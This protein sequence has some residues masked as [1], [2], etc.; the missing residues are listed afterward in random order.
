MGRSNRNR[1]GGGNILLVGELDRIDLVKTLSK[2]GD[3]EPGFQRGAMRI[4][5]GLT[6][7]NESPPSGRRA[8]KGGPSSFPGGFSG[9]SR[10]GVCPCVNILSVNS[11]CLGRL[12]RR[13]D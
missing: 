8:P 9:R 4:A 6:I 10:A 7:P 13:V 3:M 12:R 11:S 5:G 1:C 2:L